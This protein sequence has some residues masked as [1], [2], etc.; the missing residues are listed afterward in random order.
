MT[1]NLLHDS[2]RKDSYIRRQHYSTLRINLSHALRP[3]QSLIKHGE[4]NGTPTMSFL[5]VSS[6]VRSQTQP[7]R[8]PIDGEQRLCDSVELGLGHRECQASVEVWAARLR[9]VPFRRGRLRQESS[10]DSCGGVP[11]LLGIARIMMLFEISARHAVVSR[12]RSLIAMSCVVGAERTL[13]A[14][15][16]SKGA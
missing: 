15:S 6:A 16:G 5:Q 7:A 9:S 13:W 14:R 2:K 3:P 11:H 1:K 4:T 8:E 10:Q 12:R